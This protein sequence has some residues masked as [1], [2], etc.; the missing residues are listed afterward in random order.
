MTMSERQSRRVFPAG[1]GLHGVETEACAMGVA[2]LT[3]SGVP[4]PEADFLV[5]VAGSGPTALLPHGSPQTHYCWHMAAPQPTQ[6]RTVV[7]ADLRGYGATRAP[8]GGPHGE[9][10]SKREMA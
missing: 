6:T 8:A 5:A 3:D 4:V 2:G 10:Y 9:G 7:E 1:T